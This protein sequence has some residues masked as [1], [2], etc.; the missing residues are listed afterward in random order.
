M[1]MMKHRLLAVIMAAVLMLASLPGITVQ[2]DT[3]GKEAQACKNLGILLGADKSGVTTQYLSAIPTRLQAYIIALR[4][5]GLYEEAGKFTSG[6][7]FVDA[8]GAAW[9]KNYLA[10]AKNSPELGWTGYPDGRFGVNDKINGQAFYKVMLETLGYKQNV[11]FTYAQTLDFADKIG[12]LD[13]AAEM[14][15]IKSFTINDIAKGIYGALNTNLA[16]SD[17][18]LV[19]FLVDK[20]IFE[21]EKVEA[22]GFNSLIQI[23]A[24]T[25]LEYGVPMVPVNAAYTKMGCYIIEI[26]K[27]NMTYDIRKDA[28]RVQMTEGI[29]NAY[30]NNTKI[31]MEKPV[32]KDGTGIYY[33]PVSFVLECAEKFGYDA[34]YF[35]TKKILKLQKSADI[36][37]DQSEIVI[38]KGTNKSIKVEKIYSDIE[39]EVITSLCTFSAVSN[40][41]IVQVG[42]TSGEVIGKNLGS[43]EIIISYLGKEV[44]RVTAYVVDVVP[45][46]YPAAFYEQVFDTAFNLDKP[47]FTDG[48]GVVW[49]KKPG[50]VVEN[51]ED[52]SID[53]RS[54]LKILNYSAFES[55]VTVNLTKLL[56]NRAI[57]GKSSTLKIYARGINEGSKL[58]VK[59]NIRSSFASIDKENIV[60]LD[61]KWKNI[62]LLKIDIPEDALGLTLDIA[63][64]QN[65]EIRIDAFTMTLN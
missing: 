43:A 64:G 44:D 30:I 40:D 20:G 21:S 28:S 3:I 53:T 29:T 5:K 15:A 35:K 19:D 4:L 51:I 63:A 62:E 14:K 13:D 26:N 61:N 22:S 54:S 56:E 58:Y 23:A 55:G 41:G 11:D 9:A 39:R 48:F 38:A 25:D 60:D 17:K 2:A 31:I 16:D 36:K 1:T 37:A 7:N 10:Y 18:K 33:V 6:N 32:A 47:N 59:A 65:E 12:L 42:S 57:K 24:R 52:D 49:N 34:E 46:Y 50:V 8:S 27:T 45:K